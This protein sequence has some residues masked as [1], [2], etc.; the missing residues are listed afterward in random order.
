MLNQ[1]LLAQGFL[2]ISL[3]FKDQ[4]LINNFTVANKGASIIYDS[5]NSK[6][7]QK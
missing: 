2:L 3:N 6:M 5:T 4:E 1:K 7:T